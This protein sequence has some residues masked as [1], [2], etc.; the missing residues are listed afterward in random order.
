M[1]WS[2]VIRLIFWQ[3]AVP[4][5]GLRLVVAV[6]AC[7]GQTEVIRGGGSDPEVLMILDHRDNDVEWV[8]IRLAC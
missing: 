3:A 1:S 8:V 4:V 5:A 7:A 6:S 2:L